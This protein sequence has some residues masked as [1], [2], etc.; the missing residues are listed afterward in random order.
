[1]NAI[2]SRY[3]ADEDWQD[4]LREFVAAVPQRVAA[5]NQAIETRDIETLKT[6]VHQL[7]GACGSYGFDA[8]TPI[9]L[10]LEDHLSKP[11]DLE[12]LNPVLTE[13][14]YSLNSMTS[15]PALNVTV[16]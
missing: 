5:V 16:G 1:M 2:L 12:S 7:K 11:E 3:A 13:F 9:T 10:R 4:L 6:L 15:G 8:I 14:I